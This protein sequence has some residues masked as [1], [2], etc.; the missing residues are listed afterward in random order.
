MTTTD[1]IYAKNR[2]AKWLLRVTEND[3][4]SMVITDWGNKILS[5]TYHGA[6]D[7]AD[8]TINSI[9]YDNACEAAAHFFN[10]ADNIY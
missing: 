8:G 9:K 4:L 1:Y 6:F 10:M 3:L 5:G 2:L 7:N